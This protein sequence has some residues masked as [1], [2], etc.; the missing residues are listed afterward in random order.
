LSRERVVRAAVAVADAE[1]LAGLSMRRVATELG[2]ATMS[3]YRHVPGKEDLLLLMSDLVF[4]EVPLPE[5]PPRNWRD[6]MELLARN[7]WAMYRAHPW[8][9]RAISFTRPMLSPNGMAYTEFAMRALDGVG[10]DIAGRLTTV[11]AVYSGVH[12][13]A[14][15][16]EGEREAEQDSGVT[17]DEWMQAQESEFERIAAGRFPLLTEVSAIPDFDV[18]LDDLF[19]LN[20][21]LILDGLAVRFERMGGGAH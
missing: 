2:V 12:G 8:V 4:G 14:V 15:N 16:L 3:L 6:G 17:S 21:A 19:E 11:L 18:R 5:E 10:L 1:G 7:Q 9:V 20:L 13:V